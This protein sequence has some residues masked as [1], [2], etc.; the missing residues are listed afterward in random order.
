MALTHY[1]Q[2]TNDMIH[3]G[4]LD[5]SSAVAMAE[6]LGAEAFLQDEDGDWYAFN[7][8]DD[9]TEQPEINWFR[10]SVARYQKMRDFK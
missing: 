3:P 6:V 5:K 10:L 9:I 2:V 7:E 1:T 8:Y 4:N